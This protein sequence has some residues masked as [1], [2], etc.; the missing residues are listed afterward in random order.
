MMH[1]H[2]Q[3]QHLGII[4]AKKKTKKQK[5]HTHKTGRSLDPTG[6]KAILGQFCCHFGHGIALE[7]FDSNFGRNSAQNCVS[8]TLDNLVMQMRKV[9]CN[10]GY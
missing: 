6:V 3:G 2:D 7:L 4:I 8:F 5:T 9:K 1:F 10:K